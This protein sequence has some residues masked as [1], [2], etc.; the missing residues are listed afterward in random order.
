VRYLLECGE[1]RPWVVNWKNKRLQVLVA[2][3]EGAH[4]RMKIEINT[5]RLRAVEGGAILMASIEVLDPGVSE[6][7]SNLEI[8]NP[9]RQPFYVL[10]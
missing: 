6:G 9:V 7:N 4:E 8:F 5:K 2:I 10:F 1:K 3:L